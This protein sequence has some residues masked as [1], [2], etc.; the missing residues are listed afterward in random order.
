MQERYLGDSHDFIKY[1]LLRHLHRETGLRIGLN[2]YLTRPED[3]DRPGNNDGEK[4]HHLKSKNWQ[5]WDADLLERLRDFEKPTERQIGRFSG[6]GILPAD[7]CY[8][9]ELVPKEDRQGWHQRAQSA[10]AN[11]D[12]VFMDPDNGFEVKSMS[13]NSAPKYSMYSEVADWWASGKAVVS[14]Q[15]ARQCNPIVRGQEVRAKL[16]QI[17]NTNSEMPIIRGRV[18]PN[19]LFITLSPIEMVPRLKAAITSFA[20]N[21]PKVEIIP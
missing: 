15:F 11:A 12:L 8:F 3:V 18:A 5:D 13:K 21:G 1:A 14:I 20:G 4:R 16:C 9:D 6:S 10:L 2:W 17:A 7:T 19:I